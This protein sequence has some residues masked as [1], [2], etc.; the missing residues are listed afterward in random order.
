TATIESLNWARKSGAANAV[1]VVSVVSARAVMQAIAST[2]AGMHRRNT[3][4]ALLIPAH[5]CRLAEDAQPPL[6]PGI[7]QMRASMTPTGPSASTWRRQNGNRARPD[8]SCVL[9]CLLKL[10]T[11]SGFR[12]PPARGRA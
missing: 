12:L 3:D 6:S 7:G 8:A 9:G 10:L 5:S 1:P 11:F 2:M 4:I